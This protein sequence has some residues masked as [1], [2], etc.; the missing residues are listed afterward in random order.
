MSTARQTEGPTNRGSYPKMPEGERFSIA[1]AKTID[2]RVSE[3]NCDNATGQVV[4]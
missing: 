4:Q 3:S 1:I 2:H